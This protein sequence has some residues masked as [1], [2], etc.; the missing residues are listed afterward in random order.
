MPW[1]ILGT[2]D[3]V[4]SK[5]NKILALKELTFSS[6]QQYIE[7]PRYHAPPFLPS[8]LALFLSIL[9]IEKNVFYI[10]PHILQF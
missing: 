2:S 4:L 3:T 1:A 6:G 5:T 10:Y 9:K 8:F 7:N